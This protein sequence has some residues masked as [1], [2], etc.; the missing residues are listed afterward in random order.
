M[1]S[2]DGA[3]CAD[4]T[5]D[6]QAH[7][8]AAAV[9]RHGTDSATIA[10]TAG[11][12]AT[13]QTRAARSTA[14]RILI[15]ARP[16]GRRSCVNVNPELRSRASASR[17]SAVSFFTRRRS[18]QDF[19]L[20][21]RRPQVRHVEAHHDLRCLVEPPT[22]R[23]ARDPEVRGDGHVPGALDE[24]PKPVVVALLRAS[25]A[26]D[27]RPFAHAA[28]L[29]E[30]MRAVRRREMVRRVTTTRA[31]RCRMSVETAR[32][33]TSDRLDLREESRV[34]RLARLHGQ[35]RVGSFPRAGEYDAHPSGCSPKPV[36]E[37]I[38]ECKAR[39]LSRACG[40]GPRL[41]P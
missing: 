6:R 24:I 27:H 34:P 4:R 22:G 11:A 1:G 18:S 39:E 41:R 35:G 36:V 29:L 13:A 28:Q 23:R 19:L 14:R 25:H 10:G 2:V 16:L 21:F 15:L 32:R 17:S 30:D 7:T 5:I 9:A 40:S 31:G 33:L 3:T 38:R 20:E 8:R 12:P 37:R 26:D